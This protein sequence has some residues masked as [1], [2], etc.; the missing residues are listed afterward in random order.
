M[1]KEVEESSK[2]E[3]EKKNYKEGELVAIGNLANT[4]KNYNWEVDY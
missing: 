2:D 1:L 3:I 4:L